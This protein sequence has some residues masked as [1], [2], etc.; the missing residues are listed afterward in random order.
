MRPTS[1]PFRSL[2]PGAPAR[3]EAAS[4]AGSPN[5]VAGDRVEPREPAGADQ[6][7]LVGLD[8]GDIRNFCQQVLRTVGELNPPEHVIDQPPAVE[9]AARRDLE[10]PQR[11]A[12]LDLDPRQGQRIKAR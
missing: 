11:L 12:A 2:L 1:A 9:A 7:L 4:G 8:G 3:N 6:P 5:V 10:W